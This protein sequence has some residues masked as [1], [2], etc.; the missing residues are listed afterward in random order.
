MFKLLLETE[1]FQNDLDSLIGDAVL[2]GIPYEIVKFGKSYEDYIFQLKN[3]QVVFLGSIQFAKLIQHYNLE[4]WYVFANFDKL[5]CL[6]YYPRL[7]DFILNYQY[8]MFPFGDLE[9]RK[10]ELLNMFYRGAGSEDKFFLRPAEA[11][12]VFGGMVVTKDTWQ[13]TKQLRAL[14]ETLVLAARVHDI[15]KEWRFIICNGKVVTGSQYK[16]NGNIVRIKAVPEQVWHYAQGVLNN[17]KYRPDALWTLD[18][19]QLV[20]GAL[21]VLEV[22]SF[23]CAGLYAADSTKVIEAIKEVVN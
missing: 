14:P 8:A 20:T 18:V 17:V 7:A 11:G 13:N 1:V 5:N 23:S 4:N 3:E 15:V 22:G 6:Y 9:R 19:C 2:H 21:F 16:E 10:V 12:K